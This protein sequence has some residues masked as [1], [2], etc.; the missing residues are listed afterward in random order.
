M[1]SGKNSRILALGASLRGGAGFLQAWVDPDCS[2]RALAGL[3]DFNGIATQQHAGSRIGNMFQVFDNQTVK[4]F[5][6]LCGEAPVQEFVEFTYA[7]AAIDQ[8]GACLLYTSD[9]ADELRSV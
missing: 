9:A 8:V 7:G 2:Y 5:R 6:T 1:A 3:H 4:G